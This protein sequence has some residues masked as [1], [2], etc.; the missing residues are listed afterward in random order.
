VLDLGIAG[1]GD[2]SSAAIMTTP[3]EVWRGKRADA[4]SDIYSAGVLLF[5]AIAG[6]YPFEDED[7]L[8]L[9]HSHLRAPSPT[10]ADVGLRGACPEVEETLA[11]FLA[12]DP[13]D[14]W[15]SADVARAALEKAQLRARAAAAPA[16]YACEVPAPAGYRFVRRLGEGGAAAVFEAVHE[17]LDK[18]F[19]VKVLRP[20]DAPAEEARERFL[21]EAR[22]AASLD[23]PGVVRVFDAREES[24]R[25]YLMMELVDGESLKARLARDGAM[26]E[27]EAVEV[28]RA[29]LS[30]LDQA[31]QRGIIHRDIKPDNILA[32]SGGRVKLTDFGLARYLSSADI[33]QTGYLVGTPVYMSPE[34]VRGEAVDPR[35]DLYSLG[36]TLYHM[37]TGRPPFSGPTVLSILDQHLHSTAVPI[38]ALVPS[39]SPGLARIVHRLL[40]KDPSRRYGTAREVL[41]ALDASARGMLTSDS[42]PRAGIRI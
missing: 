33:T 27:D 18:V 37:I 16:G 32:S 38:A 42:W 2:D 22:L 19:A 4:R 35:S 34:Q 11:R 40:L 41:E 31:H 10:L 21:R 6:R 39:I 12:K 28:A 25:L 3:P 36:A 9:C 17:T 8:A 30:A 5:Y 13:R 1:R 24:G 15:S 20:S 14:R 23:H 29:V 7:P 26:P